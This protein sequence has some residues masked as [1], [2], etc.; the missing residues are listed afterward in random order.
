HTGALPQG[1]ALAQ[2]NDAYVLSGTPGAEGTFSL[3]VK[4]TDASGQGA[5]R[6]VALQVDPTPPAPEEPESCGC[7]G[8]GA[9]SMNALGLAALALM[10]RSRRKK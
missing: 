9:A 7:S 2:R 6:T 1:V 10:R 5:E 4:V 3:A 8:S